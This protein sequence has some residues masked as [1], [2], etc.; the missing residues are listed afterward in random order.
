MMNPAATTRGPTIRGIL[1]PQRLINPPDHRDNKNIN[2]I[3]GKAA[4]PAAVVEYLSTRIKFIGNR[5]KKTPIAAYK[6]SVNT[7]APRKERDLKSSRGTIGAGAFIST[8]RKRTKQTTPPAKL[9]N[10][11]G[12]PQPDFVDSSSPVTI[13]PS[14]AV[15]KSAPSQSTCST[16]ELRLSGTRHSEIAITA[17]ANG[18]FK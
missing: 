15:A 14:P 8:L 10:T 11:K 7:F 5:K 2:K 12:L 3:I 9:P 6:N 17:A 16:F 1:A 4:A 13:P 18:R